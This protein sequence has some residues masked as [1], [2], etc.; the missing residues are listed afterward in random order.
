MFIT[1]LYPI[2]DRKLKLYFNMIALLFT[3]LNNTL[4]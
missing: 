1:A 4:M 2:P 3:T